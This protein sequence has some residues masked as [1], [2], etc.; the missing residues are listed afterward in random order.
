MSVLLTG[1]VNSGPSTGH[2]ACGIATCATIIIQSLLVRMSSPGL[3]NTMF[4]LGGYAF[5]VALGTSGERSPEATPCS[6]SSSSFASCSSSVT[7]LRPTGSGCPTWAPWSESSTSPS[8]SAAGFT[9]PNSA[10]SSSSSPLSS[11]PP[12]WPRIASL[13]NWILC[14]LSIVPLQ[15]SIDRRIPEAKDEEVNEYEDSE[16]DG[17]DFGVDLDASDEA[18]ISAG[19]SGAPRPIT[20][21]LAGEFDEV[22]KPEPARDDSGSDNEVSGKKPADESVIRKLPV[23][24]QGRAPSSLGRAEWRVGVARERYVSREGGRRHGVTARAVGLE[25]Q[26]NP[27]EA[28][29]RDWPP[30]IAGKELKRWKRKLRLSFGTSDIGLKTPPTVRPKGDADPSQIPLP[31]TPKKNEHGKESDDDGV[32]RVK[33]EGTPYLQD[34]HMVTPRSSNRADR[35]ARDTEASNA[36]RGAARASSGR[37]RRRF[38]PRDDSSDDDSGEDDYYR[39]EGAEYDDPT[40]ELARQVREVSELERLNATPRLELAT[41][42][43]LAQ[44]KAFSGL[45]ESPRWSLALV[46]ATAHKTKRQWKLLSDAFI[47]YYCSQFR[48][49]AKVRYYSA[50]REGSEH[51]CDYVN[52]LNG[53]ARN[54]GVQFEKGGRESKEHVNRF[55]ESCGDRGLERRLC[56]LRVK[57]IHE[58]ED[59]VNDILKS[60][61]RGSTRETSAY[62]SR[63]RDRSHGRD[64]RRAETSRDGYRRDRHDGHGRGY[65][66]RMDDSRHTPRI[67]LAEA[68]LSEMMAELQVREST[69]GRSERSKSRDMRRSL[70]DSSS[71]DM[72][73]R[74][75]DE[76]Q[77]GSDYADPYH[78]EEHD[79]HVAAA[80]DAERR[81]EAI[82][83]PPTE[84][85]LLPIGLPQLASPPVDADCVYAFVGES[86]WLKTQR[87]EE[88]NEVN[89][90]EIEKEKNGTF[91]GGKSDG[92]KNE[93]WN[94][95]SSECLVSSVTQNTWHDYRP[96]N[97]TKL[98]SGERL[99]WWSAQKFDKRVRMRALVQGAVNDAR[100]RIMLDTGANVSVSSERFAKQLRLREVRDHG[101]CMEIQGFT[102]RT[103]ATT[104]RALAKGTLGWNQVYEYEL[105]VMDHGAGEDVVLGTDFMIPAGVRLDLFHATARLPDEVEIPLI[106]TQRMA[107]TREEGPHV[108]D[109]PTEVLTIPGHESRDYRP[110]R[111]PPT[112]E[113][114][115]LWLRRTKELIPKV[116]DFRQG[117]P[118]RVRVT[119]IS[120]R[121]VTCPVHIPLLLWVPRGDLPR[122][123]GYVRLGSDKDNEWRVLVYSRSRDS[124]LY[125]VEGEIY[126]RW[127]A[128]QPSAVERVPYTTPTKI[129][130]RPSE[131]SA[132]S[133]SDRDD[134][135]ECATATTEPSTEMVAEVVHQEARPKLTAHSDRVSE[136]SEVTQL[137]LEGAYL[138]AATVSED[139]GDRDAPNASEHPGNDIEFEDYARELAF[140]PDLTEAASTT[141]DYTG[142]HVRHPSLSV[143]QQ[144]RVMEVLKSHERIMISSGNAL[145][146]PAYGVVCDID[147]Q[148]HPPIKQKAR[149]IPLRHLKQLYELLK[150]LLMAGL[151]AFSNSPWASP[152]VIVLKKNGVDIRLCIDYKLVNSV[153]AIMEY[154]MLLVDDLLTDME[155]SDLPDS[156]SAVVND[157]RGGMFASGEADQSSLVPVFERRSFVDDIC[158][159]GESFD[160]CLETLDRL[161]SRFE[162]CRISV[163]FTKSMFVQ[164]TIDF[165]SHAVSREGL[166]ADAKKLKAITELSFPKTS[167]GVQ[168]F[169]GALNYYSRFIQHFAVYGAA[170]SARG[171]LW[172][173]WRP[174]H[175]ETKFHSASSENC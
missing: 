138:A 59:I 13:S 43:P 38:V 163:S 137:K 107:D 151:I 133:V 146:P 53:Y 129:P 90:T 155:N 27:S 1:W 157:P 77:S 22:A 79:R 102:K 24:A 83:I 134:Q 32:F 126:K 85:G 28:A 119:N 144:D 147:V 36:R 6:S 104:K 81:T 40:D 78:S 95:G 123:E 93:E 141:L 88:V 130:S 122:T 25:P 14:A 33:T 158:F 92:R 99:G 50:K 23:H 15:M 16:A 62:L 44:I 63:G 139:W 73:D 159:G 175:C 87:R 70:E 152:I 76:D 150:G 156:L 172:T 115:E 112:N 121:S 125:K 17:Y 48:Q 169:L 31:Q 116:G 42:R 148:E 9:L 68:S 174:V 170:L 124:D 5:R 3:A 98:L 71:E 154:A 96:E 106:K 55:L 136:S 56:H 46:P 140:L 11:S 60:E 64:E 84:T 118:R 171:R 167:K 47:N 94:S 113:T 75:T 80:N 105:W 54:A 74:S 160:S 52:R 86:K 10:F 35:L 66:H 34:S 41:H 19:R 21:N 30:A 18:R 120:D 12:L 97:V 69:Y 111:Q 166:R 39:K 128:V 110:M 145:P 2:F 108:R 45:L 49:S 162:G 7:K 114:H 58:P 8:S 26:T 109:G 103:L 72:E 161:L 89:T 57:D 67:S 61:E 65:D 132:G 165:L 91:G 101:R 20:R 100:T 142:P 131:Y 117:R 164:P 168:A 153:T 37:S 82:G 135:A 29:L 149:R 143:E 127:L 173:R 51:V 4:A